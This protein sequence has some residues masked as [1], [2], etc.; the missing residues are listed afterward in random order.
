MSRRR[1]DSRRVLSWVVAIGLV[2]L[3]GVGLRLS[4]AGAEADAQVVTGVLGQPVRV[5]DGEITVTEVRVGTSLKSFGDVDRS[6]SMFV[7]I[8]TLAAATGSKDLNLSEST[9]T[10]GDATYE[11]YS[12]FSGVRSDPG[13]RT[14]NDLVFEV[15]PT[16]INDLA[17]Q[18]S[19]L[20]IVSGYQQHVRIHLGITAGNADQWRAAAKD[21]VVEA[22][23]STSEGIA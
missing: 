21:Q 1:L 23:P 2:A 12:S 3:A 19:S 15:D 18:L 16:R 9:L 13:F 7:V 20:E 8:R 4:E 14:T 17:L 5:N 11:S 22:E 6:P 10:S